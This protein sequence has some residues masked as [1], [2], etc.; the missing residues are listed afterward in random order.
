MNAPDE[1]RI[2]AMQFVFF[3]PGNDA[4]VWLKGWHPDVL[5]AQRIVEVGT[6]ALK[7]RRPCGEWIRLVVIEHIAHGERHRM[8]IVLDAQEEQRIGPTAVNRLTLKVL[9]ATD[10]LNG[11]ARVH[12]YGSHSNGKTAQQPDCRRPANAHSVH[13][14]SL[15]RPG[16]IPNGLRN[17]VRAIYFFRLAM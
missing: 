15:P 1:A 16:C 17:Q 9:Q 6:G 3:A 10:L 14:L 11:E 4:S 8:Q 5:A 7:L 13:I 2:K 12:H